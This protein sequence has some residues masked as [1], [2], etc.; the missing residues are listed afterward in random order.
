MED[1]ENTAGSTRRFDP[2]GLYDATPGGTFT[3][4]RYIT[5]LADSD[6]A[7]MVNAEHTAARHTQEMATLCTDSTDNLP[8]LTLRQRLT[9]VIPELNVA[10]MGV[11]ATVAAI[12]AIALPF[13]MVAFTVVTVIDPVTFNPVITAICGVFNIMLTKLAFFNKDDQQ[14]VVAAKKTRELTAGR[15][16]DN[17]VDTRVL[18]DII[19]DVPSTDGY[20]RRLT[21]LVDPDM[22][23]TISNALEAVMKSTRLTLSLERQDTLRNQ[24]YTIKELSRLHA[25]LTY[26]SGKKQYGYNHSRYVENTLPIREEIETLT[27]DFDTYAPDILDTLVYDLPFTDFKDVADVAETAD[28]FSVRTIIKPFLL[29]IADIY[30]D[31]M[32]RL[33]HPLIRPVLG[34]LIETMNAANDYHDEGPESRRTAGKYVAEMTKQLRLTLSRLDAEERKAVNAARQRAADLRHRTDTEAA[35]RLDEK[36]GGN[37]NAPK[38]NTPGNAADTTDTDN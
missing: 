26:M 37:R 33:N 7:R 25:K 8:E 21:K 30:R 38:T 6:T 2:V 14:R 22:L 15:T 31:G 3:P 35:R 9:P 11:T 19:P 13:L 20:S 10:V 24:F 23:L 4:G 1:T 16:D 32:R 12:A 18:T 5:S 27:K 36:L 28:G 17:D 34:D 29:D